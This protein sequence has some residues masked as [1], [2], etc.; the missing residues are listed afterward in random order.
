MSAR[1][2]AEWLEKQSH[3]LE[4]LLSTLGSVS[5]LLEP[6]HDVSLGDLPARLQSIESLR[7]VGARIEKFSA[8]LRLSCEISEVRDRDWTD[9]RSKAEWTTRFLDQNADKGP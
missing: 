6:T 2:F 7:R 3:S 4:T 1:G 5:Q 9:L 8:S